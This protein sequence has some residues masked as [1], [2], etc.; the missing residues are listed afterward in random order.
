MV[1]LRHRDSGSPVAALTVKAPGVDKEEGS[2]RQTLAP[3]DTQLA[4]FAGCCALAVHPPRS[5]RVWVLLSQLRGCWSLRVHKKTEQ[6]MQSDRF[7]TF[8]F[9]K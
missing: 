4:L 5:Q 6:K 8:W 9:N 3:T 1:Q 7:Q 2:L